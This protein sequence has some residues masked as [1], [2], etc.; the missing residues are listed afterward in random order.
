MGKLIQLFVVIFS[1]ILIQACN[2][3]PEPQAKTY[4]E[5]Q[6][7]VGHYVYGHEVNSFQPCGQKEVYW[8][9]GSDKILQFLEQKYSKYTTKPYDEVYVELV[10]SFI[11]KASDG[12]SMDYDDQIIV[13]KIIEMKYKEKI[14]CK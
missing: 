14:N 11:G 1:L 13:K 3:P 4:N 6:K 8:V 10:G 2:S 9:T 5:E 7:L 12:F